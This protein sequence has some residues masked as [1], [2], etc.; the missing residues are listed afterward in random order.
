MNARVNAW[1]NAR[2]VNAR[3]FSG[4]AS[5]PPRQ[6]RPPAA[7]PACAPTA[8]HTARAGGGPFGIRAANEH[9]LS[10]A[11]PEPSPSISFHAVVGPQGT[12]QRPGPARATGPP[13]APSH[14]GSRAIYEVLTTAASTGL[15]GGRA[16]GRS[17]RAPKRRHF[18]HAPSF[19]S[20]ETPFAA[21]PAGWHRGRHP[22]IGLSSLGRSRLLE[23]P[24][25][26]H[27][28]GS[29]RTLSPPGGI[30]HTHGT[31]E[32]GADNE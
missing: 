17:P 9:R 19:L 27:R 15:C 4:G 3:V 13:P 25:P 24:P 2:V 18:E 7:I 20:S 16:T 10:S 30:T 11:A 26:S 21:R 28:L 5:P 29:Y 6:A 8:R 23:Q 14:H 12:R 1:T 32:R 22:A 31:R